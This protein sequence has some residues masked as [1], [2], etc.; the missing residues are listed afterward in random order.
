MEI[1]KEVIPG[2]KPVTY[3][4]FQPQYRPLPAIR[5]T[6]REDLPV[7]SRWTFTPEERA[8]IAAGADLYLTMLTFC[9]PLQPVLLQVFESPELAAFNLIDQ[10]YIPEKPA[11]DV[12]PVDTKEG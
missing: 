8:A 1:C 2:R 5:N 11:T 4:E 6:D 9:T 3:A 12:H 10:G 7:T